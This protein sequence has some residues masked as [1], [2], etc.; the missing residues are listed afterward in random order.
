MTETAIALAVPD[1]LDRRAADDPDGIAINV[2]GGAR[3]RYAAWAARSTA[4]AHALRD[5]GVGRGQRVALFFGAM[6][7][8]DY[9]IA[10]LAV[11]RAGATAVHLNDGLSRSEIERRLKECAV[12]RIVHSAH[13][14][15]PAGF[16]G[17]TAT[18]AAL[19]R[20]DQR[21]LDASIDPSDI[22][23]LHYTSGTTGPAKA[24]AV[25]HGNLT[26]GRNL[27]AFRD[28][29][30]NASYMLVPMPLG[31]GTSATCVN[32]ALAAPATSVVCWPDDVERMA[33]LIQQLRI[34][35]IAITP[36]IAIRMI[37][38]GIQDRYD[39]S[40]VR[41]VFSASAPLPPAV[42]LAVLRAMPGA[43][44][45]SACSQSEAGPALL[46]D[47]FDAS[48]PLS[49]GRPSPLT[50]LQVVDGRGEPVPAGEVGEIW[51]RHPAPK[52]L[53]LDPELN[54]GILT[55]GWYRTGDYGR[56]GPD[57]NLYFFDRDADLI[58]A[59]DRLVST[60]EIEAVLYEHAAVREAA[61]FGASA[62][63][64]RPDVV[65]AVALTDPAELPGVRAFAASRFAPHQAPGRFLVLP[66]L[67]RGQT[68]KVL[69]RELR[70]LVAV[71]AASR[72]ADM[73]ARSA[74]FPG[75]PL[76][77]GEVG[78][79]TLHGR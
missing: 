59:G 9:A 46:V 2:D 19:D 35:S 25:P 60:V 63:G 49:V 20:G 12:S 33:E 67:P 70:Q 16:A 6:D 24:Y 62:G 11:L 56:I 52:R 7:W 54:R 40:S 71:E 18:L 50:E 28:F 8:I 41:M 78:D 30:G 29:G 55:D 44:L 73:P 34:G 76:M 68:G 37:A 1:V 15:P 17:P 26:F 4:A 77:A 5:A 66:A 75:Q 69:K 61:V 13:L 74:G 38:A 10:Y 43:R 22:A 42:A 39:L 27:A 79:S 58:R 14:E 45:T 32:A 65:A 72:L 3:L 53:Y 31:T 21:P 64:S 47:V 57:D 36:W 23:D 51:L 48:R